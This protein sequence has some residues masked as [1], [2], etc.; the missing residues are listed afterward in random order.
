MSAQS[1]NHFALACDQRLSGDC[2]QFLRDWD[3]E[4]MFGDTVEELRTWAYSGDG[5][6]DG[7]WTGYA[8]GDVCAPCRVQ[9]AAGPHTFT[10]QEPGESVC[11][12]C[13]QWATEGP[14][15]MDVAPGQVEIPVQDVHHGD[16]NAV[17]VLCAAAQDARTHLGREP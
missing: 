15:G 11:D 9:L 6:A 7:R 2:S 3:E 14:H 17:C 16:P 1:R 12:V 5:Q 8:D 4:V 10:P 13:M